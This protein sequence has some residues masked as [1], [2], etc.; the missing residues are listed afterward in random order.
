M[1]L[2]LW[3]NKIHRLPWSPTT[4]HESVYKAF[5]GA[6]N[7]GVTRTIAFYEVAEKIHRSFCPVNWGI[8][9]NQWQL[10]L[11]DSGNGNG[12]SVPVPAPNPPSLPT[13]AQFP[14]KIKFNNHN[15]GRYHNS[16]PNHNHQP[17][18]NS[19]RP[20]ERGGASLASYY[21]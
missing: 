20:K 10:A 2:N 21:V 9:N 8:L 5:L 16:R 1:K 18:R 6:I 15:R 7:Q 3:L 12:E 4:Q 11:R 13:E 14:V 17:H 19:L